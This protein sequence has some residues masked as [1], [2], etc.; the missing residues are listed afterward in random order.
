MGSLKIIG[1]VDVI[2][3]GL[4]GVKISLQFPNNELWWTLKSKFQGLKKYVFKK[5]RPIAFRENCLKPL[6]NWYLATFLEILNI[7]PSQP[8]R[9][10]YNF[11]L[12][13]ANILNP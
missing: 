1:T 8:F 5:N 10:T 9:I 13:L 3:T 6:K 12:Q 11:L 4:E 7:L 2:H